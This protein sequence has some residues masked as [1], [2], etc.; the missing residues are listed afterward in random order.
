VTSTYNSSTVTLVS[1]VSYKPFG[2]PKGMTKGTGGV[3]NNQSSDCDCIESINTGKFTEQIYTYDNNKNLTS[4]RATNMPHLDKDFTYDALSRLE[5]ATNVFGN[6]NYTYDKVGNRL[7]KTVDGQTGT[8]T[9][10]QGTNRIDQITTAG[11]TT[12]YSYDANGNAEGI[13]AWTLVYN[14][15]NRLIRV[16][17]SGNT[18]GEYSYNGLG[19]RVTKDV[20]G[21]TT[22]FHYD[23][24]G[25]IIAESD[26]LGIMKYE[27]LYV[28]EGR[29][30]L[31]DFS[32]G[33]VYHYLNNYLGTPIIITNDAGEV[34][35]EADYKPFGEAYVSPNSEIVNNFRFAGQYYDSETGLHYNYF[36]YYHP[37]TGRYLRADPIGLAGGINIFTYSLNNPISNID[38]WGL[39]EYI[40]NFAIK[41]H[42]W[43]DKRGKK[44]IYLTVEGTVYTKEKNKRG[45]YEAVEFKG[46]F[47]GGSISVNPFPESITT[48]RFED[49]WLTPDVTRIRGYSS[50]TD[51]TFGFIE[52]VSLG[53]Y[54]FGELINTNPCSSIETTSILSATPYLPGNIELIGNVYET[55]FNPEYVIR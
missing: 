49:N 38:P 8:Y 42:S 55:S 4:I 41:S 1:N 33:S 53:I 16:E 15:G 12:T 37:K 46:T 13:G 18:L 22:V 43:I 25:N 44:G 23:F 5:T 29:M 14:Q 34:V 26:Y 51:I 48:M 47:S 28:N 24:S 39:A 40:V 17:E 50:I 7:T 32:T 9:Y 10:V 3:V 6:F 27:Y 36:R 21:V 19:Q 35:W 31:V 54:K 11:K 30:A 52:G 45:R 2:K 20:G